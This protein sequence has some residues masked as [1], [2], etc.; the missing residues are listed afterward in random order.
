MRD[1]RAT[2]TGTHL[3]RILHAACRRLMHGEAR[4]ALLLPQRGSLGAL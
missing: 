3:H 1:K 2:H 4:E